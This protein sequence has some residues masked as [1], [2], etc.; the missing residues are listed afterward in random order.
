MRVHITI[1]KSSAS[2]IITT[3]IPVR[4]PG[5]LAKKI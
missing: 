4:I 2:V 1:W 3:N 5:M